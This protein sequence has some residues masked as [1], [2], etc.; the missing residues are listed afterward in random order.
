MNAPPLAFEL[1]LPGIAAWRAG[2]TGAE[3]VWHFESGQPGR[4]VARS[5]HRSAEAGGFARAAATQAEGVSCRI[6]PGRS[7]CQ[8][9]RSLRPEA[10]VSLALAY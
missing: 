9:L 2:N 1:P 10:S 5:G 3:G 8:E 7:G 6:V 4:R